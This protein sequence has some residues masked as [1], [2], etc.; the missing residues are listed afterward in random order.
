MLFTN[1]VFIGID[2]TAGKRPFVYAALDRELNLIAVDHGSIDEVLAFTAAHNQAFVGVCAP[3][4]PN[5]RLMA[6]DQFRQDLNPVPVPGRWIK[7]RVADYFLRQ[8]NIRT[9]AISDSGD[10]CPGWMQM[11][12]HLYNRLD[13]I[14]YSPYPHEEAERQFAEVYPHASFT[15][16]LGRLPFQKISLDF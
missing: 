6:D 3:K 9:T 4:R 13:D 2:P 10:E 8:H 16:L 11:G 5:Q 14:G 12:F 7:F 1:T 15:A